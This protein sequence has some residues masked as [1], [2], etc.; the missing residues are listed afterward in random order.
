MLLARSNDV[1][2]YDSATPGPR[3]RLALS[4]DDAHLVAE[5]HESCFARIAARRLARPGDGWRVSRAGRTPPTSRSTSDPQS[6]RSHNPSW[7]PRPDGRLPL[8]SEELHK[9]ATDATS[10]L[11]RTRRSAVGADGQTTAFARRCGTVS[12]QHD[13][14]LERGRRCSQA[15]AVGAC[16]ASQ[17]TRLSKRPSTRDSTSAPGEGIVSD[18]SLAPQRGCDE[19]PKRTS[20]F[21]ERDRRVGSAPRERNGDQA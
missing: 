2:R 1:P 3:Q 9:L 6:C 15:N 12:L 16:S 7:L 11:V 19:R 10:L 20:A 4:R 8:R 14:E 5:C 18:H 17:T 13:S 21:Q